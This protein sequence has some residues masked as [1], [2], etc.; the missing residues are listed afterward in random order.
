MHCS[1]T[2][3]SASRK[4]LK[5]KK[6]SK[7][8]LSTS[9]AYVTRIFSRFLILSFFNS[10]VFEDNSADESDS[11]PRFLKSSG[12]RTITGATWSRI[13][14]IKLKAFRNAQKPFFKREKIELFGVRERVQFERVQTRLPHLKCCNCCIAVCKFEEPR[15][16]V[17]NSK[18][19]N[20]SWN[21][22]TE[23]FRLEFFK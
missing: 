18:E 6:I 23:F 20:S 12:K 9:H 14:S 17:F 19:K 3:R 10:L 2:T 4:N 13:V 22:S 7:K 15:F 8:I 16:S 5:T 21:F 11:L 1:Y